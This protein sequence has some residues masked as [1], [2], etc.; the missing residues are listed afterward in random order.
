MRLKVSE[1][2]TV[3][4][5][6]AGV[7]ALT[8][9]L[10]PAAQAQEG[11][12]GNG[13][14]PAKP[15]AA[16]PQDP[17]P[18]EAGPKISIQSPLV[19]TPVTV[20]GRDGEFVYDLDEKDFKIFDDG[21]PQKIQTFV[22]ESRPLAVAIVIQ[23]NKRIAPLLDQVKPLAPLFTDLMLGP[24]GKAAV[25]FYDDTVHLAQDF[26]S[27]G[28]LLATTLKH[29]KVQGTDARLNDAL[30]RAIEMLQA[31]PKTERRVIVVFS[32]SSDAGSSTAKDEI[33]RRATTAEISIYGL[34][35][36]RAKE[37]LETQ[38]ENRQESPLDQNVTRPLP[39]N[40]IHTPTNS[41]NIYDTPTP[42]I[43]IMDAAG[44]ILRSK[45]WSNLLEYYA[46]YTGGVYYSHWGEKK[47]QDQLNRI[48]SE[49]QSQYEL[50]YVPDTLSQSG[51]HRIEIKVLRPDVRVR[52][53]AGYFYP[54]ERP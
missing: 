15:A 27:D 45:V 54:P 12:A 17:E 47:L 52:T 23:D 41:A 14:V 5:M 36:S 53:R 31:R 38:P 51:F 22:T 18:V 50:A 40:T 20:L 30:E 43:P 21:V 39:P 46:G 34:G 32:D 2:A 1:P 35:F 9:A 29:V 37:L 26:S 33:V 19:T 25:L 24:Q 48:A 3:R 6:W 4:W 8:F 7:L 44:S 10:C 28:T 16:Q 49:I 11:A 42:V 13:Q